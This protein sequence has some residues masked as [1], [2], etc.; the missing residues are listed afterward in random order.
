MTLRSWA[1][2][3]WIRVHLTSPEE[4]AAL[5]AAA[6]ADLDD[7][8]TEGLSPAWAFRAISRAEADELIEAVEELR[9]RTTRWSP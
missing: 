6:D 5:V 1:E 3:G 4:L 2:N 7:A 8:R 9:A